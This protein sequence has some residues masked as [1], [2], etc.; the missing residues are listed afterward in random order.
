MDRGAKK[1]KK[2][3]ANSEK[4]S[5]PR[6]FFSSQIAAFIG[7]VVDFITVILLT[8]LFGIWYVV[9]NVV[10]AFFG[11]VVNFWLGRSW[12][13]KSTESKIHHQAFRYALVSFGSIILNTLGVYLL[14]EYLKLNYIFSKIIIAISIAFTY[15]FFLQKEFVFKK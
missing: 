9:S 3:I 8:E 12:V 14:T 10:G 4:I 5:I 13:F 1:N 2:E 6:L 11:A 15:N 7:T